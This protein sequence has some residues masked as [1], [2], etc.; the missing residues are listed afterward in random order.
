MIPINFLAVIL[1]S[2]SAF[3]LGGLWYGPLFGKLW[4]KLS[5]FSESDL[6]NI[7]KKN[8]I[9]A[10][11]LNFIASL[12]MSYVLAHAIFF[13]S[14]FTQIYGIKAGLLGAFWNWFGFIATV[15]L[16]QVLWYGQS[17]KLWLLNNSYYF[18]SLSL[19]GI[20]IATMK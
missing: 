8:M 3:I 12:I 13:A 9:N 6:N 4:I 2:I 19:M 7:K 14:Q 20:I 17:Y 5:N 15:T 18:L 11:A 1:A 16:G 10:Y